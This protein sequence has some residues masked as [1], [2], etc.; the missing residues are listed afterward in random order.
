VIDVGS[1]TNI[2]I[3]QNADMSNEKIPKKNLA[4]PRY[5]KIK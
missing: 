2:E 1:G 4:N 3:I 5:K